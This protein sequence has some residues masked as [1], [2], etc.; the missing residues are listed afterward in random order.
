MSEINLFN[1]KETF[2]SRT[3]MTLFCFVSNEKLISRS[4]HLFL[5]KKKANYILK[6]SHFILNP[7]TLF[8]YNK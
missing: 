3:F 5:F 1:Y 7:F 4:R 2:L 8:I 6:K